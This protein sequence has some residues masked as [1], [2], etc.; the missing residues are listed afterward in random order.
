MKIVIG[1]DW[2]EEAFAAVEQ[3]SRLY[4]P[5]EV[6][7]VHGIEMGLFEYPAVAQLAN[8]QGYDELRRALLDAGRQVLDRTEQLLPPGTPMVKKVNEVGNPAAMILAAAQSAGADLIVMGARGRGRLAEAVLGSVSHRVLMHAP[9]PTLIVRG[10]ARP[11][12]RV[13][14][15]VEGKDDAARIVEWLRRH[16]LGDGV[17][18]RVLSVVVPLRLAE[19]YM[20]PGMETWAAAASSNAENLVRTTAASLLR[21]EYRVT[22]RVATG[23][24][25]A[26]VAEQAKDC[27]LVVVASHGRH[28]V[29]RFLLGSV[30][31]AIV[32]RVVGPVLVIH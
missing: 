16:P 12:Q 17:E 8:L 6:T 20:V 10:E 13:L 18:L 22:T 15:A 29:D 27:D 4:R 28:G 9:C 21:S 11:V 31:H 2:S 23:E 26:T 19:P 32:H 3:V 25:A 14:V 24:P 7:L 30:S 5:T 1:V